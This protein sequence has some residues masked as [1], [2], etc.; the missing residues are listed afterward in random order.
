MSNATL[1]PLMPPRA[2][3]AMPVQDIHR[4]PNRH[5]RGFWRLATTPANL[6]ARR[7]F[8]FGGALLL[9]AYSVE[10]INKVFNSLGLSTLGVIML[11][12]FTIL[13]FWI[14]LS[15]VSSLGGFVSLL[16]GGGLGLGIKRSGPL[17][18]LHDRTAL[19]LPTYNEPPERLMANLRAMLHSLHETGQ[20]DA[21]D[22]FILSDTTNPD[23]WVQEEQAFLTLNKNPLAKGR[24]FYRRRA[25][26]IDRK[27]GNLGEWV[28]DYGAA[29]PHMLTLDADSLMDGGVMVRMAAAMEQHP[30]VG[31]IQSLPAIV[32]GHTLFARMQQFAGRIYGPLIAHGIAWWHGSEGNYW[33]HNA[34]IRT[35]AFAEQAGLPHLPGKP[36]FGGHILSHDFIEAAL[37]RRGGWAIHMVPGLHGSYE[38]SPPSLTDIAIRDRRWCQGNLQHARLLGTKGLHWISRSHMLVGMG[39]YVMSPL[40]LLFLLC[41]ILISLQAHFYHPEYFG[42]QRTLYPHWPHVDPIQARTV[43]FGTMFILLAPKLLA[44]IASCASPTERRECGGVLALG[45]SVLLETILGALIAPI[46]ML[47]QTSAILSI[48]LGRDSGWS[49][50]NRLDGR[51]PLAEISRRY[52]IYTILGVL[53]SAAAW[54]VSTALFLWMIPVLIGL[55]LAI[56]L[57]ALTSSRSFGESARHTGLLLIPEESAPPPILSYAHDEQSRIPTPQKVTDAFHLLRSSTELSALHRAALPPSRK[58]GD[59]IN[60]PQLT[61][62][63]KLR[64]S[65]SLEA[66]LARL[67]PKE[68]AAL[69]TCNEGLSRL[70]RLP[71]T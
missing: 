54:S 25:H 14:S 17:P 38:E 6:W 47:I 66:A 8:V 23:I 22:V 4:A 52:G 30:H 10:K 63:I 33:G 3:L 64:E 40:W 56:P 7:V 67:N 19:L 70:L 31:L 24:V 46:A 13:S 26:N 27:A 59:P 35:Q 12:L 62:L 71:E 43:F 48:L 53:L 57:V 32:D 50:Q 34:I 18:T 68:K 69:L 39:A 21:F 16:R 28:R 45:C 1:P 55:V 5:G 2:P 37:M 11:I 42:T 41:G 61:G 58:A 65:S 44:F 36:P 20:A 51:V 9:T 29:Y 15:F 49:A 60:I